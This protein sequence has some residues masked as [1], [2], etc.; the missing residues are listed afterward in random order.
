MNCLGHP[1][2]LQGIPM[3]FLLARTVSAPQHSNVLDFFVFVNAFKLFEWFVCIH[4][5]FVW[6]FWILPIQ[7]FWIFWIFLYAFKL[8]VFLYFGIMHSKIQKKQKNKRFELHFWKKNNNIKN[9]KSTQKQLKEHN[10][11]KNINIYI[12]IYIL[13]Y[14]NK[15]W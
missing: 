12:Y 7:T 11:N 10:N 6:L 4:T 14:K 5:N 9:T 2:N 13:F 1:T 3:H 15:K 8:F